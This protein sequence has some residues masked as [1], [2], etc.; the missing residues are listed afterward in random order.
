[1]KLIYVVDDEEE[2]LEI[3]SINLKAE[4][5]NVN[6]FHSGNQLLNNLLNTNNL[7]NLII[8]DIMMEGING[9]DICRKIRSDKRFLSIPIIFLTA[10]TSEEDRIKG[11]ELGG[12]DYII[13]PFNI[14]ELILR[15]KAVLKRYTEDTTNT[16]NIHK[17]YNLIV[18]KDLFRA[19]LNDNPLKLT[20]TE[21]QILTLFFDNPNQFFSREQIIDKIW[22]DNSFVT[23]RTVDVHIQRLRT[24][25]KECK[26]L[27]STY[28]GVGYGYFTE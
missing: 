11:L 20:K 4:N 18:Y 10:K 8:L 5:Y 7:P 25:L 1:V 13:K 28:S 3:I 6:E 9:L 17:Y 27:I 19:T 14:K 26:T 16:T 21:F 23:E 24:K 2:I 22:H 15:V 12:D